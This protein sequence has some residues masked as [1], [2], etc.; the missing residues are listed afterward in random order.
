MLGYCV[1]QIDSNAELERNAGDRQARGSVKSDWAGRSASANH[2]R[3]Q[4]G[5]HGPVIGA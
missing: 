5:N 1:N 2:K 4:R 3:A